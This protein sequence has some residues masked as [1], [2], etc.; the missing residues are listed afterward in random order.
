MVR[1]IKGLCEPA[2]GREV[3]PL[4]NVL[5]TQNK[6]ISYFSLYIQV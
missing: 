1:S 4:S 6:T 3:A 2:T 5:V